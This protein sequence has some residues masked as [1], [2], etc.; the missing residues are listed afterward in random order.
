MINVN[1]IVI[2]SILILASSSCQQSSNIDTA[3]RR[4][5]GKTVE[6]NLEQLISHEISTGVRKDTLFLGYRLGMTLGEVQNHTNQL[7]V[8]GDLQEEDGKVV[9][10]IIDDILNFKAEF[11]FEYYNGKVYQMNV[12]FNSEGDINNSYITTNSL[13]FMYDEKYGFSDFSSSSDSYSNYKWVNGNRMI[14]LRSNKLYEAV[15]TYTDL[16]I[17]ELIEQKK[18]NEKE[19]SMQSL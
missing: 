18:K 10:V 9:A 12:G 4:V 11:G 14:E 17:L 19:R 6:L 3:Q 16:N 13:A 5:N 7:L 2:I 1:Y 8:L 15:A